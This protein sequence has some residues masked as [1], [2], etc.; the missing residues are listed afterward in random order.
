MSLLSSPSLTFPFPS[1]YYTF[2][3]WWLV[4][5]AKDDNASN[6]VTLPS[7]CNADEIW[8]RLP[9]ETWIHL[10]NHVKRHWNL[11]F[12]ITKHTW[13]KDTTWSIS[14][15]H[16]LKHFFK[17]FLLG[18]QPKVWVVFLFD[19]YIFCCIIWFRNK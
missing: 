3:Q 13:V 8:S 10:S 9:Y 17:R 16:F 15:W 6:W 19:L 7:Y 11:L 1:V 5:E 18:P 14:V 4:E 12:T 2:T